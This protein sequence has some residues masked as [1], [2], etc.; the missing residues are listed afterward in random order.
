METK[1]LNN[2]SIHGDFDPNIVWACRL[3]FESIFE[4][5]K[6][7]RAELQTVGKQLI[8]AVAAAAER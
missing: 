2:C 4:E 8:E 7:L 1:G 6:K 5:N 3:C